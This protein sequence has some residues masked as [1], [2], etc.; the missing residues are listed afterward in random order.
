MNLELVEKIVVLLSEYPVSE[1]AVESGNLKLHVLKPL[2][3]AAPA[4]ALHS[5]E[6]AAGLPGEAE[7]TEESVPETIVLTSPMVGIFY[8]SEPPLP[9]AAEIKAGQIVGSIESMKLMNDVTAE[10]GG[11]IVDILVEDG[12]PVDY[13]R[14]LFRLAVL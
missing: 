11:R 14:P 13:G 7:A 8:H 12:A 4:A 3:N 6:P 10:A 1:I 5:P 2:T 9:F